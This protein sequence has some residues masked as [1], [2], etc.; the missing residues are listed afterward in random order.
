MF[1]TARKIKKDDLWQNYRPDVHFD[2]TSASIV[3]T[4]VHIHDCPA[5]VDMCR[6][7]AVLGR[8]GEGKVYKGIPPPFLLLPTNPG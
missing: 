1:A 5:N 6:E 8:V 2:W 7:D 3:R 4:S